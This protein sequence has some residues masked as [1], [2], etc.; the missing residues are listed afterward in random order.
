MYYFFYQ[1]YI[2]HH[3]VGDQI[4]RTRLVCIS[5]IEIRVSS[6]GSFFRFRRLEKAVIGC[7]SH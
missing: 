3:A 1:F 5:N 7:F 4:C 2:V 6:V